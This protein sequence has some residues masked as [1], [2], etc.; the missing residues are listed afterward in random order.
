[1]L[2]KRIFQSLGG[3][4][5]TAVGAASALA[6]PPET[7]VLS[8]DLWL[9]GFQPVGVEARLHSK[10]DAYEIDFE[11]KTEGFTGWLYPYAMTG[12]ADGKINGGKL[13]PGGYRTVSES[14]SKRKETAFIYQANGLIDVTRK[15]GDSDGG[16]SDDDAPKARDISKGAM[17]PAAALFSI[18][19]NVARAEACRGRVPVFDGKRRYDLTLRDR[20]ET[21]LKRTR[22]GIYSGPAM[23]CQAAVSKL[24]GFKTKKKLS[25]RLPPVIDI[26]LAKVTD[27][28]PAVPV[29][30]QGD[31]SLGQVIIHLVDARIEPGGARAF[32]GHQSE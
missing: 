23:H 28:G 17:D 32:S 2:A 24:A 21:T 7:V 22:Y 30:L 12:R 4:T 15:P 29:R 14:G 5:A 20:G 3:L 26:W 18:A 6:A 13:L 19:E 1:M 25:G 10:D 16:D 8:Y 11:A 9:G 27:A 31:S